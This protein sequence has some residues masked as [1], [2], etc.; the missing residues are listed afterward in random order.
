[1]PNDA[2]S[3]ENIRIVNGSFVN[4]S[5]EDET[6]GTLSEKLVEG[7]GINLTVLNP[8][9]DEQIE[10]STEGGGGADDEEFIVDFDYLS[11]SPVTICTVSPAGTITKAKLVLDTVFDGTVDMTLGIN[12]NDNILMD[13]IDI[14]PYYLASYVTYPDVEL[15]D[16]EIVRLYFSTLATTQG[17]GRVII[18]ITR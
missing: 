4:I 8:G 17:A 7:D 10:I 1:M 6:Y 12:G 3:F 9:G 13:S 16:G 11:T 15:G 18:N 2:I 5:D 14:D